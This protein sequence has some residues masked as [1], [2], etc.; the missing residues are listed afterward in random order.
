MYP[1]AAPSSSLNSISIYPTFST[2][3][4]F[5]PMAPSTKSNNNN[6]SKDTQ[7]SIVPEWSDLLSTLY[8][9]YIEQTPRKLQLIDF[10]IFFALLLTTLQTIYAV[11]SG[12]FP[13]NSYLSGAF[14]S[15]GFAVL[16]VCLRLQVANPKDFGNI[17]AESAF[18]GFIVGN[19]ALFAIVTTFMG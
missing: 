11:I 19:V 8:D 10:F 7:Q 3:S 1:R 2:T 14:C 18:A 16:C 9:K 13:Y 4:Q 15:L 17:T 6:N 12:F 5:L